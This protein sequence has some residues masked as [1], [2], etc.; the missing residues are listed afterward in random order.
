MCPFTVRSQKKYAKYLGIETPGD[1]FVGTI[2]RGDTTY[3][4]APGV[5]FGA[6]RPPRAL[7]VIY[8]WIKPTVTFQNPGRGE[9]DRRFVGMLL[10]D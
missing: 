9:K 3:R 2:V 5:T 6:F 7:H 8:A 10:G 4:Y 1:D